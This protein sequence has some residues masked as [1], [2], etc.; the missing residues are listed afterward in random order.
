VPLWVDECYNNTCFL[1][2]AAGMKRDLVVVGIQDK[3]RISEVMRDCKVNSLL[4][5]LGEGRGSRLEQVVRNI[6]DSRDE[7]YRSQVTAGKMYSRETVYN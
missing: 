1:V 6:M 5:G 4:Y 3:D 7:L 2:Y